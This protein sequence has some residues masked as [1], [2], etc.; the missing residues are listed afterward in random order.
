MSE[1]LKTL[2][3]MQIYNMVL[4]K[5]LRHEAIKWIK[6][7]DNWELQTHHREIIDDPYCCHRSVINFIKHFFN[8]NE[9]EL[10]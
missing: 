6:E 3:D 1:E 7:F 10:K 9:E 8:I 4:A 5:E 2:K